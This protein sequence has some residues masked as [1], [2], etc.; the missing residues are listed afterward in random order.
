M[1]IHVVGQGRSLPDDF[2]Y[3]GEWIHIDSL[4]LYQPDQGQEGKPDVPQMTVVVVRGNKR[5][6]GINCA[7]L[8]TALKTTPPIL[9]AA[10]QSGQL[11]LAKFA[12]SA[13]D[14]DGMIKQYVFQLGDQEA[15]A[16]VD[17][18]G[19]GGGRA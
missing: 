14:G 10:N 2:A 13:P 7:T 11:T 9:W 3:R 8:A 15:A 6:L 12:S 18:S 5:M 1:A 4:F 17:M 19:P 16:T